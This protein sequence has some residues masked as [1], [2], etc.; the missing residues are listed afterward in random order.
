MGDAIG[1]LNAASGKAWRRLFKI[2]DGEGGGDGAAKGVANWALPG[3]QSCRACAHRAA[4]GRWRVYQG[5]GAKIRD[6]L[7]RIAPALDQPRLSRG[8]S[9]LH[10]G[11][12]RD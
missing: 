1:G 4:S 9:D 6:R 10:R 7:S 11:R 2:I 3:L 5:N 12:R 8:P